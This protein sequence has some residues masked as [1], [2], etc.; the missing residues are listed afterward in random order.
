M[1]NQFVENMGFW[2]K[3]MNKDLVIPGCVATGHVL[4]AVDATT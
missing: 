1:T 4:T 3:L 2:H